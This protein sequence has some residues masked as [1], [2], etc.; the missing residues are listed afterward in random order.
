MSSIIFS[1]I[2]LIM[3]LPFGSAQ[4]VEEGSALFKSNQR[5]KRQ[6]SFYDLECLGN[7]D[8]GK[9]YR[10]DRICVECLTLYR[11]PMVGKA[12]R[13]NCFN[14]KL[15]PQCIDALKLGHLKKELMEIAH[16]MLG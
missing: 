16:D 14:N 9:F 3:V 1:L 11:E 13:E 8:I 5:T 7:L 6:Y 10:L 15:F 4:P 2:V 12:C